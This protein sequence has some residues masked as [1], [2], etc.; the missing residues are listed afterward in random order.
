MLP[1][2]RNGWFFG[3]DGV[4]APEWPID[5]ISA[6]T[7]G[8]AL[9]AF[10]TEPFISGGT[11]DGLISLHGN[12]KAPY[13]VGSLAIM[14]GRGRISAL[15]EEFKELNGY[16]EFSPQGLRILGLN[17]KEGSRLEGR[18]GNGRF[19]LGGSIN[20]RG[21]IPQEF[22]LG[23]AG[24]NLHLKLPFLDGLVS[25]E[26][27]LTG[28]VAEP[29]LLGEVVLRKARVGLPEGTGGTPPLALNLDLTAQAA[30]DVYFR[31]YGMAYVPFTGTIRVG[32]T[33]NKLVLDG[34]FTSSRGW[35]NFM[36]DTFRIRS[37]G[38]VPPVINLSL[39]CNW[40]QAVT[41]PVRK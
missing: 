35:V 21:L 14:N 24:E 39:I 18:F 41:F 23:L 27:A 16:L 1:R 17:R 2:A 12:W 40:K 13:L 38:D 26:L 15:G 36:G 34:T 33:L 29:T 11:I 30:D 4:A 6:V 28:A 10:F 9:N 20:S 19:R 8:R 3:A 25:G 31:M 5:Q 22:D 7:G 32:G 37:S